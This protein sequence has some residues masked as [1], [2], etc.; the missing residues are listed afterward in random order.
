MNNRSDFDALTARPGNRRMKAILVLVATLGFVV[1]P[2]FTDGFSGFDPNLFPVPQDDPPTQPAGYA[3]AIWGLIYLWLIVH[4]V[5]G[6]LKRADDDEWDAPRWPLFVSLGVGSGWIGVANTSAVW[7]TVLIWVMLIA[8]LLALFASPRADRWLM[9]A[10]LA[11]YAGWLTGAS[12]VSIGLMVGG[13]GVLSEPLAAVA[14]LTLAVLIGGTV[15]LR[16]PQAPEYGLTVIWA[17]VAVV[18][19][20][21]PNAPVLAALAGVGIAVMAGA[22]L[23]GA[24]GKS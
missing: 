14:A 16:L 9:Q 10:P 21:L 24:L 11:I 3:F 5:F 13:Y 7:A 2:Y 19:Q 12:C 8:A 20:N 23:R 4:A 18:V 15:Q 22:V 1:S 17:L 6:L